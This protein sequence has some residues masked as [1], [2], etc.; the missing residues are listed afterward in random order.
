MSRCKYS[1]SPAKFRVL[2]VLLTPNGNVILASNL[3]W[4][5]CQCFSTKAT[6]TP[7]QN[8]QKMP[9]GVGPAAWDLASHLLWETSNYG[10]GNGPVGSGLCSHGVGRVLSFKN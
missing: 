2:Q 1:T 6:S 7:K 8:E 5:H 4:K 3:A 9:K 10:G